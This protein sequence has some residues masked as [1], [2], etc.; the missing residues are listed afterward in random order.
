[1]TGLLADQPAGEFDPVQ[2]DWVRAEAWLAARD[3]A[4]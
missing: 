2:I 4:G 1:L 3:V